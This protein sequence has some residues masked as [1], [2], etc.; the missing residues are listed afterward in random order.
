MTKYNHFILSV[1]RAFWLYTSIKATTEGNRVQ[2]CGLWCN[3]YKLKLIQ[4]GNVQLS[5]YIFLFK[6]IVLINKGRVDL[7]WLFPT[8]ILIV[9]QA[10]CFFRDSVTDMAKWIYL[11]LRQNFNIII[12]FRKITEDY[13]MKTSL[14]VPHIDFNHG[15]KLSKWDIGELCSFHW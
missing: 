3:I 13:T 8:I 11:I 14:R 5:N 2:K 7:Q 4:G 6:L 1:E 9:K 10:S 15:M 12:F